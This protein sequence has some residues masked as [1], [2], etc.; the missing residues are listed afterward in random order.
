MSETDVEV[1][2]QIGRVVQGDHGEILIEFRDPAACRRCKSGKGCGAGQFARLFGRGRP[3]RFTAPGA[4]AL[5]LGTLVRV[6]IDAR[7]L[8]LAAAAS[9]LVPVLAFIAGALAAG[10]VLGQGDVAAL[11][12]GLIA[13]AAAWLL[14]RR[15]APGLLR[16]ALRIGE[17]L[18]SASARNHLEQVAGA[19][20]SCN[21]EF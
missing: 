21:Q 10:P 8:M 16:P 18:E 6:G 12:G 9:Y 3:V 14:I 7:W 2:W 4:D 20:G 17:A 1:V 19:G 11:I 13:T 5:P 15:L